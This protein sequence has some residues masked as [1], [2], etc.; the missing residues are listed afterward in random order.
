MALPATIYRL[1][2][3]IS[4]VDRGVYETLELQLARHPSETMRYLMTRT[5]AYCLAYEEGIAFSRGGLSSADEAPVAVHD[6]TGRLLAWIDVGKPSADRLHKAS[7]AADRLMI[8]TWVDPE[9]L[10][11]E[12]GAVHR[13]A[14]ILVLHLPEA[15]L[16][17]LGERVGRRT[18]LELLHTEGQLYATV[19]G[20]TLTATIGRSPL[21]P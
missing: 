6:P 3:A 12:A 10:R 18:A 16:E 21:G 2:V 17:D 14:E 7:K 1:T 4:D 15:F 9:T 8:Y 19:D 5:L 20:E 11:R 13:A